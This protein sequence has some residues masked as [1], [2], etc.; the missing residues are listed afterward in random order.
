MKR[1]N[2]YILINTWI[3]KKIQI[4]IIYEIRLRKECKIDWYDEV[5]KDQNPYHKN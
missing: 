2:F 5:L 3:K 1:N 4:D